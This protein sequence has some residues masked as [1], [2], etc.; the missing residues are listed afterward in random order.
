MRTK[1]IK[2]KKKKQKHLII[3]IIIKSNYKHKKGTKNSNY[4]YTNIFM[5]LYTVD[6]I[7]K[8]K[9][10]RKKNCYNNNKER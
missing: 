9:K 8:I 2:K 1:T 10:E 6:V 3:I 5:E 7:Y 4:L